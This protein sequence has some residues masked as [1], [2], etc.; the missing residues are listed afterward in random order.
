MISE[1]TT[2]ILTDNPVL[3]FFGMVS[4]ILMLIAMAELSEEEWE[5]PE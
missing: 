3:F 1:T 5:A 2:M 4:I